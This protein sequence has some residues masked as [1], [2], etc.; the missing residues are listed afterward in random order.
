MS[1]LL[2]ASVGPQSPPLFQTTPQSLRGDAQGLISSTI[3]VWDGVVANI[4]P[5]DASFENTIWPIVQ[6]ENI[7]S[8]KQRILRFYAST[9]P[10]K[11]LRDASHAII[12]LFN[13]AEVDLFSRPDMFLRVDSVLNKSK[14]LI[15]PLDD[16]SLYYLQKLHRR[17]HQNGCGI[18]AERCRNEFMEKT[19][20]LH[21]LVQECNKNLNEDASGLWLSRDELEGVPESTLGR[22]ELGDGEHQGL[23]WLPMKIPFTS[24]A[25]SNAKR[26]GTRKKIYYAVQNRMRVN[27]PL[28]REIVLLRDETAR[29]LGYPNHAA[30]K[31]ADKMVQSPETVQR[32]LSELRQ[33]LTPLAS[34]DAEELLRVKESEADARGESADKVFFWDLPYLSN[35]RSE[36]EQSSPPAVSEYFELWN[37]LT[38]LLKMFEHLLGARFYRIHSPVDEGPHQGITWHEDVQAY[39]V[40]NVD[41][42]EEF[43]GYAYLDLFP[44]AGKNSH[45]GHY[46]LQQGY[47]KPDKSRF[48]A[49]SVLIMNYPRPT[50]RNPTL[51]VDEVRKLFHE[52]GHLLHALFTR[53]KYASLQFVDRDFVEAPS[54]MLEQFFS[55]EHHI[56]D[57]SCH[58]SHLSPSMKETWLAN[59]EHSE[60]GD[61]PER[62][63]QLSEEEAAALARTSLQ[64]NRQG[65]LK[66]LFFATYDML[67]HGPTSHGELEATNLTELFNR[68]RADIYQIQG[69][70]ALGEG[71]E[72][73]HGETVFRNV[74]N[75]YD[76][77]YY[78]YIL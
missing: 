68:T 55:L 51:R 17:F 50:D 25:I 43:L 16:E 15:P 62:P 52:L 29:M 1:E 57:V 14:C 18:I 5:E 54:M 44:R 74:L 31:T 13:S 36:Q 65:Q 38:K 59:L 48:Y 49:S 41:D 3:S 64:K 58:Y 12:K 78:S 72:W 56:K 33:A 26:E 10:V 30:L 67:I 42:E 39:A 7:R 8:E 61:K 11:D 73:A 76:A 53:I 21:D 70:E 66:E 71:W 34:R 75:G 6:D 4:R 77:G 24:P 2:L 46:S 9:S 60:D 19:K 32:L 47:E 63:V 37:T 20:R 22:L 69:G 40:W 28:F 35:R 45:A 27:V 23:L